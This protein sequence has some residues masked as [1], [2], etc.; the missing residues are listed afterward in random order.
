MEL[1]LEMERELF[2][3]PHTCRVARGASGSLREPCPALAL[4]LCS[5]SRERLRAWL[6]GF[7]WRGA[8]LGSAWPPCC[9]FSA[10][11]SSGRPC[12]P[13]PPLFSSVSAT[14]RP[15]TRRPWPPSE[16]RSGVGRLRQ[17]LPPQQLPSAPP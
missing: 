1:E 9:S 4:I 16:G 2:R 8:R 6:S 10:A 17:Q 15:R 13:R 11:P 7:P 3:A 12:C 5:P 14:T